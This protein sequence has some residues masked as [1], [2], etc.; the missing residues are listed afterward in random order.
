MRYEIMVCIV[1][2]LL[3]LH[4]ARA[5]SG[6]DGSKGIAIE[7]VQAKS[8]QPLEVKSSVFE[9]EK[10]IPQKFTGYGEALTVPLR[11]SGAPEETR[12]FA[13]IVEDPDAPGNK[14]F[15]HWL[16]YDLPA[17]VSALPMALPSDATLQSLGGAR[18]GTNS[19]REVGCFPPR[20]PRGDSAH[21]Y[22]FQVFALD[23]KLGLDAGA[24]LE[25]L[26]HAMKGHVL[27]DGQTVG[28]FK[29]P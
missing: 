7:K 2:G 25:E 9:N 27:A 5:E 13:I 18:Q 10:W 3:G 23:Q 26:L 11:W 15:V 29:A 14:P 6:S 24:K 16:L 4:R 12:A 19:A 8:D 17:D 22:H 20:P 1:A 21:H 28:I